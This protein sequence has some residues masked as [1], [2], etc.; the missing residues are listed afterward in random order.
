M[1]GIL[2]GLTDLDKTLRKGVTALQGIERE[3]GRSNAIALHPSRGERSSFDSAH[4]T[5]SQE[6]WPEPRVRRLLGTG[7][8][9]EGGL[10]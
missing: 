8:L 4:G 1:K 5:G 3:L 2:K 10:Q 9:A 7:S 6:D